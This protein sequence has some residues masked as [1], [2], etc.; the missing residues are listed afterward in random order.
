V[1]RKKAKA[2][3]AD[4]IVFDQGKTQVF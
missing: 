2:S 3:Q 4:F 1:F